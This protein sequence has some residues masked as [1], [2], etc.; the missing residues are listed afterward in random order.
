MLLAAQTGQLAHAPLPQ[1][2]GP[3]VGH[4][5]QELD[6]EAAQLPLVLEARH[7]AHVHVLGEGEEAVGAA[8]TCGQLAGVEA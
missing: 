6:A 1:L 4:V 2:V 5:D 7:G 8:G 3:H